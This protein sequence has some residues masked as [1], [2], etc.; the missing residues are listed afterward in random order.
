M[1]SQL[2]TNYLKQNAT[3]FSLRVIKEK[4]GYVSVFQARPKT[5]R[6]TLLAAELNSHKSKLNRKQRHWNPLQTDSESHPTDHWL[7]SVVD[8]SVPR[9]ETNQIIN[10]S[11]DWKLKDGDV[12]QSAS[13]F[14]TT[15]STSACRYRKQTGSLSRADFWP[16]VPV[17]H[18]F[19]LL[20]ILIFSCVSSAGFLN[21]QGVCSVFSLSCSQMNIEQ[22]QWYN[23]EN[24]L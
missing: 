23:V 4:D 22:G 6:R 15:D 2:E 19:I 21:I 16:H 18:T 1:F 7:F 3:Y 11:S 5:A 12:F 10:G 9:R 13:R 20:L 8:S 17:D 14:L 24:S